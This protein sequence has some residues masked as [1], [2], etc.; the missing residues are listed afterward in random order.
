MKSHYRVFG[1]LQLTMEVFELQGSTG[2]AV[3]CAWWNPSML[4]TSRPGPSDQKE[5][6]K[7]QIILLAVRIFGMSYL[8]S[9]NVAALDTSTVAALHTASLCFDVVVSFLSSYRDKL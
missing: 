7:L 6:Y 8:Q 3:L 5:Y 2:L 9:H 1:W 4:H